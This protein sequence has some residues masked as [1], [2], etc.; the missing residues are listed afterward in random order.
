[1]K[2]ALLY[3][4][5]VFVFLAP[6]FYLSAQETPEPPVTLTR[7]SNGFT[8]EKIIDL[9]S[10]TKDQAYA[11]VKKWIVANLKTTDNNISFDDVE[12]NNIGTSTTMALDIKY[13]TESVSFKISISFKENK[14]RVN[15]SQ[16][17]LHHPGLSPTP[18]NSKL[19]F[20]PKKKVS[21]LYTKFDENFTAMI[22][23]ITEAAIKDDNW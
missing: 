19:D 10:V 6:T 11:R 20:I 1:M 9:P 21:E 2:T 14:M 15:A 22:S 4:S 23:A 7:T 8:Y 5:L 17:M 16:F 13:L 12:K 18:F 3:L